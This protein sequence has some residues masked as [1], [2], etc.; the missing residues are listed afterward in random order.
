MASHKCAECYE[1]NPKYI[2][3]GS[4]NNKVCKI[5]VVLNEVRSNYTKIEKI[6]MDVDLIVGKIDKS[7]TSSIRMSLI[8]YARGEN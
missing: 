8:M 7:N 5:C 3:M 4:E 6:R 1:L 2:I